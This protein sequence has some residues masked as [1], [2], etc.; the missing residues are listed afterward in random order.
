M[1]RLNASI[2]GFIGLALVAGM[3]VSSLPGFA[4]DGAMAGSGHN[5][6]SGGSGAPVGAYHQWTAPFEYHGPARD[7][8]EGEQNART[9]RIGVLTSLSGGG[10]EY[11]QAMKKGI[12]MAVEEI[13]KAGGVLTKPLEVVYRDDRNDMGENGHQ[14][15]NLIFQ[16]KVWAIIGSVHSGCTHV[17]ARVTLKAETPQLTTV[18]TDPTVQMIGSPWMFR[19]LADDKAQGE[20]IA[21][22]MFDR[23]K[24]KRVGLFQQKNRYG[25]MGGK[26]IAY[27]AETRGSPLV[28]KN[29]FLPG[30]TDFSEQIALAKRDNPDG[31]VL[32]GLYGECAGLVRALRAAGV[33]APIFGADGMVSPEFIKLAGPSAEGVTVTYP[34]DDTRNDPVTQRFNTTFQERYGHRPDS[35]SAHAYDALYMMAGAIRRGGLNKGRIRDALAATREFPGVTGRISFNQFNDDPREVIFARIQNGQFVPV[36]E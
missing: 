12:D 26:T 14:T 18:S 32:W 28:F 11:G 15:V 16:D 23:R 25:K 13:N 34:Y 29:F 4:Q 8:V 6:V 3:A 7:V 5:A 33:T 35:F 17:A 10:A 1:R 21:K 20:A 9:I 30:Q 2:Q 27:I 19:C 24:L 36:K 31:I 22:V